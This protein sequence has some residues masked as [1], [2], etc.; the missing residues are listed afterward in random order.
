MDDEVK[1]Y[2]RNS[3]FLVKP[4]EVVLRSYLNRSRFCK[5]EVCGRTIEGAMKELV[6]RE[7]RL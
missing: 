7:V 2:K 3:R 1:G 6:V 5:G 4:L